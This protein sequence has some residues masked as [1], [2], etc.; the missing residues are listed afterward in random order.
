MISFSL[1]DKFSELWTK[2]TQIGESEPLSKLAF[3]AVIFLDIFMLVTIFTGLADHTAQ[4]P[5]LDQYIPY[6]CRDMVV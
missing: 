3:V 5:T 4:L 2:L 6:N 1:K